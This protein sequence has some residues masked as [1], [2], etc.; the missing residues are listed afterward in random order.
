MNVIYH[1]NAK[2]EGEGYALLQQVTERLKEVVEPYQ[3]R[4]KVEWD[5]RE[6]EGGQPLYTL[7]IEDRPDAAQ[8]NF[9]PVD[10]KS[11]HHLD[12]RLYRLWGKVLQSRSHR[13]LRDMREGSDWED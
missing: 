12:F 9:A 3:D 8:A 4:V 1:D 2:R 5:R 11:G 10:L 7:R 6:D 13:L